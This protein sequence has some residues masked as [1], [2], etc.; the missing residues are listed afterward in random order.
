MRREKG[1]HEAGEARLGRERPEKLQGADLVGLRQP[2]PGLGLGRRRAVRE[3]RL[4]AFPNG[5]GEL[6]ARARARRPD[7]GVDP[8]ALR[9]DRGVALA[10]EAAGDL[11]GAVAQPDRMRVRVHETRND[12]APP[13]VENDVGRAAREL[14]RVVALAS[15]EHEPAV[16]GADR[17]VL[18]SEDLALRLSAPRL[19]AQ[20]RREAADVADFERGRQGGS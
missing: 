10:G 8:T 11:G 12:R 4:E 18:Q 20:R 1:R 14:P 13:R 2:V 19:V 9:G 15:D 7:R 5:G 16:F 6:L 17:R 3:H